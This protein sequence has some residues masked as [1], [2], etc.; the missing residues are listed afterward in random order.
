MATG[1]LQVNRDIILATRKQHLKQQMKYTPIDA[2]LA[3]AQ[4]QQ[5]PRSIL[6][7]SSDRHA[8]ML[9]VQISRHEVYDPVTSAL[10]CLYNGANAVSFFTDHSIYHNDLDDMLLLARAMSDVPVLYQNYITDE[11]EVMAA[12]AANA[13]GV[14]LYSGLVPPQQLRRIVSMAQRWKMTTI[15]QVASDAELDYALTVSPH[16]L[17][18]GDNLSSNVPTTAAYLQTVRDDLPS[19]VKTM[20]VNTIYTVDDLRLAL[21][22]RVD[23]VI[24]DESLMKNERH[25]RAVGEMISAEEDA[26]RN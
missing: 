21:D 20:L 10:H 8:I 1:S 16:A 6:N 23:A 2:V 24:L 9:I 19:Y 14:F 25:A 22:A 3:L 13:S 26:R 18:F 15:V 7:Y 5:R 11:Y 17:A 4:M 12:R